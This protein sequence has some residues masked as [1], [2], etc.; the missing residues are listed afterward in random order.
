MENKETLKLTEEELT[1]IYI[2]LKNKKGKYELTIT[3]DKKWLEAKERKYPVTIDP[4]IQ[5]SQYIED[6]EDVFIYKGDII[7]ILD[8]TLNEVVKYS[9]DSWGNILSITDQNGDAITYK[10]NIGHINPHRR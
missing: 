5:T 4:T 1:K 3:P 2:G 9:Y 6:I 8:N 10:N 7:G